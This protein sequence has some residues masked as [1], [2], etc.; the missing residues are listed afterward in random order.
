MMYGA[1]VSMRV[2]LTV[3]SISAATGTLIGA[4]AAYAGGWIDAL[5]SSFLF[6]TFL[7]FP[8]ILLAIALVAFRGPSLANLILALCVIGWV[9]YARLMRGQVL[10]VKE[11]DYVVA[12]R[13]LGAPG[14][15]ILLRHILPNAIQ[16]LVIQSTLG[17]AGAVLAE[18]GLSFLGL[19]VQ[20][21]IPSWG[22]ML[23]AG[24]A[25]LTT[26]PHMVVFPALAIMTTVLAFNFLGDGLNKWLD[27][28][29]KRR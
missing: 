19:G 9:G 21:P 16:P 5:V 28:T 6:N 23:D 20:E 26:A 3:V 12:A 7:A 4:S 13:A 1:R 22:K 14:S 10:K 18:A 29:R 2:G 24:R 25:H 15:R 17:M 8:G 11:Y 27:P